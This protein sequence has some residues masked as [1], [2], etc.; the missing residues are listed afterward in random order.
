MRAAYLP[1]LA[2]HGLVRGILLLEEV[3]R[4]SGLGEPVALAGWTGSI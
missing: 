3:G 4:E 1:P 2:P